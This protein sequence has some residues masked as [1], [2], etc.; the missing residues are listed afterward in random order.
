MKNKLDALAEFP[1]WSSLLLVIAITVTFASGSF[2]Q[3]PSSSPVPDEERLYNGY[4]VSSTAEIGWRFRSLDGNED[5]YRSDLN[6]KAGFRTFDSSLLMESETGKGKYFDSL[7]ITNS[8]WGSDP[9]GMTKVRADKTGFYKFQSNV[10]RVKYY[11]NLATFIGIADPNQH[12]QDTRNT[13]TDFDFTILPQNERIRFN[14]GVST[15]NYSGP[16]TW[17]MRWQGDEFK[18]DSDNSNRSKDF[19]FGAEGKL[20]GFDWNL[21]QGI[22]RYRDRTAFTITSLNEGHNPAN[23]TR[24]SD[25]YRLSP[26]EGRGSYTQFNL[27]RTFA[28]KLDFTG[29]A[30]YS[31]SISQMTLTENVVGRN[32]TSGGQIFDS[33]LYRADTRAKRP[34]IRADFGLTYRI[35]EGFRL[36]NTFTLDR[37]SNNGGNFF[38]NDIASRNA[39]GTPRTVNPSSTSAYIVHDYRRYMNTVEGDYQFNNRVSVHLGYRYSNRETGFFGY[40]LNL[41]NPVNN[42]QLLCSGVTSPNPNVT[43]GEDVVNTTHTLLAGMRIKPIKSWT[44]YWDMEHGTADSIF[45]RRENNDFTNFRLRSKYRVNNFSF[46]LAFITRDNSN[47]SSITATNFTVPAGFDP[48]TEIKSRTFSGNFSW[49]PVSNL[50]FSAGYTYRQLDSNT[51]VY[52]PYQVCAQPACTSGTTVR[53][54]ST[55][56]FLVRDHYGYVEIAAKPH[57][58][59]GLFA[60]YRMNKD[61]GQGDRTGVLVPNP[62]PVTGLPV[63]SNWVDSYP[64]SFTTPEV[65][66]VIRINRRVDWNIGY[67]YYKYDDERI[68]TQN[69]RAHLPYTSLRI[70]FGNGA[71]DR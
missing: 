55:S 20:A 24:V 35:T 32:N 62:F 18:V 67:Q 10:R 49:D 37:F 65:K 38:R 36:S 6:Y 29:R 8:G 33:D 48:I 45:G 44:V 70:Y 54:I 17:T 50:N 42:P 21:M 14:F 25:F 53:A 31:S 43:C 19:R 11:N 46:D 30:I 2:G 59:L 41:V 26:T 16:G 22:W 4:K 57:K 23:L 63:Y 52:V 12:T 15:S 27:H 39:N 56:E 60:A 1:V 66:A 9:S 64:M 3:S 40:S 28:E 7:L 34:Q 13:M 58:R 51:P 61:K 47:P 68:T 71:A 69:Y 5:K